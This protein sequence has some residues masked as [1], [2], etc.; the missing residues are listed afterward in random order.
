[1]LRCRA[2][3]GEIDA[4]RRS[5]AGRQVIG[6]ERELAL[7]DEFVAADHV[8]QALVLTGEP[9]IGKTT[10]VRAGVPQASAAGVC[11]F[12]ARPAAGERELPNASTC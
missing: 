1:M 12:M 7:L 8:Q 6:R 4:D 11:V 10:I 9:G 5:T 2:A 3:G